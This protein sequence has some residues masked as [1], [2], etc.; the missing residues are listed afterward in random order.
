M[1]RHQAAFRLAAEHGLLRFS[2]RGRSMWPLLRSGDVIVAEPLDGAPRAGD[3][4][5]FLVGERFVAHRFI[6]HFADGRLR[7]HGDFSQM[8]D[9]PLAPEAALGR[10]VAYERAGRRT[11]LDSGLPRLLA[12]A[13]PPLR[14]RAPRILRS[15]RAALTRAAGRFD[16]V[17]TAGPVRALRRKLAPVFTLELANSGSGGFAVTAQIGSRIAGATQVLDP[18]WTRGAKMAGDWWIDETL[19]TRR[20]RGLGIGRALSEAAIAELRRRGAPRVRAAIAPQNRRG[21]AL[22]QSLGFVSIGHYGGHE[23]FELALARPK[24][25]R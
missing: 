16:D 17:Y 19:V 4:L 22:Y 5:V 11:S 12:F 10:V 9:P 1:N 21:R 23:L 25:L 24:G 8:E 2:M 3:V 20:W 14:R 15:A 18:P 7:M 6:G 13:L